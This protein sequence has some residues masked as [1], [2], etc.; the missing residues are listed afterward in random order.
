MARHHVFA[1]AMLS[2]VTLQALAFERPFPDTAKRG[3]MTPAPYP[4]IVIDGKNRALSSGARIWNQENLIELPAALRGQNL[5]VN[6]TENEQGDIDRVW[7]LN[8]DEA[9]RPP[10][11]KK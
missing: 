8:R 9:S 4:A 3:A 7:I 6:Y 11:N 10:P 1:F 5:P 2:F